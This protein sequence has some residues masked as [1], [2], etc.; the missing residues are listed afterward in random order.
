MALRPKK[1]RRNKIWNFI[2]Q[3]KVRRGILIFIGIST[4][5]HFHYQPSIL[6][7]PKTSWGSDEAPLLEKLLG[8]N[9]EK[10][11]MFLDNVAL[12]QFL[13]SIRPKNKKGH[14]SCDILRPTLSQINFSNK[15]W[16]VCINF[17]KIPIYF[18]SFYL[19]V[20]SLKKVMQQRGL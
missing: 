15:H 16:Q 12:S 14:H 2:L 9:A 7:R 10:R 18:S 13:P 5:L 1:T 17:I 19:I 4:L 20:R 11:E 8:N 6:L 3:S